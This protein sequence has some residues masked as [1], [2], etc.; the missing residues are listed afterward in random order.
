MSAGAPGG[1]GEEALPL[2]ARS[3]LHSARRSKPPRPRARGPDARAVDQGPV[4][5]R[6]RAAPSGLVSAQAPEPLSAHVH[7]DHPPDQGLGKPTEYTTHE[8]EPDEMD[9]T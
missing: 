3:D 1:A 5:D 6:H 7:V 2:S 4:D 9:V 8:H